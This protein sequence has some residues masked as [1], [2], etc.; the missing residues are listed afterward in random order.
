MRIS[1]V[2]VLKHPRES[3]WVAI[4]DRLPEVVL[5]LDDIESVTVESRKEL[6]DGTVDLV[7][8]WKAKPKLPAI[9]TG[10][11]KTEM[12]AWTDRAEYRPRSYEC[13]SARGSTSVSGAW[14]RIS[15]PRGSGARG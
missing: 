9:V 14:S 4:R 13:V 3:V 2:S 7:N 1:S 12:L 15:W 8:I 10:Y 11:I 6:P 5:L